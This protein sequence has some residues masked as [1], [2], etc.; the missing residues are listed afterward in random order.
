MYGKTNC[1][2]VNKARHEMFLAKF[3]NSA[4]T[5]LLKTCN[6]MDLNSLPPCESS[7]KLHTLRSHYQAL[8]WNKS[9]ERM[10]AYPSADEYG[11]MTDEH[12]RWPYVT[13]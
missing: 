10:P 11:W 9:D 4:G 2:D 3:T 12:G 1:A 13:C 7:L 8:V 6:G 5:D